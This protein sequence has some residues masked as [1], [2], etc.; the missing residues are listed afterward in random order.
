MS[1]KFILGKKVAS[2]FLAGLFVLFMSGCASTSA[3]TASTGKCD[4]QCKNSDCKGDCKHD[5]KCTDQCKHEQNA[6]APTE[7]TTAAAATCEKHDMHAHKHSK[8]CG[9][10]VVKHDDHVDY[11]H[12]GHQ[13]HIHDQHV[14]EHKTL[15]ATSPAKTDSNS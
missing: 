8:K 9:H 1:A 14:D 5:H 7:Q 12:D 6:G 10:K 15:K 13:H 3:N 4:A 2:L 11:M